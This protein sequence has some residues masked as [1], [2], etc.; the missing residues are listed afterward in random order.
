[1]IVRVVPNQQ[2]KYLDLN[3]GYVLTINNYHNSSISSQTKDGDF[4]ISKA[5]GDCG[6]AALN[7]FLDVYSNRGLL[8]IWAGVQSMFIPYTGAAFAAKCLLKHC[9]DNRL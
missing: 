8:S 9:V 4:L 2:K 7:C 6:Q 3:E 5:A 1:M